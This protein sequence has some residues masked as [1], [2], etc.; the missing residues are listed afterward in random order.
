VTIHAGAASHRA[1]YITKG[2]T[3]ERGRRVCELGRIREVKAFSPDLRIDT[4]TNFE[5]AEQRELELRVAQAAD[6]V[7]ARI[8]ENCAY[9]LRSW[10]C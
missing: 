1:G 9:R 5:V 7:P 6:D 8:A 10:M 3:C 2:L 4:L